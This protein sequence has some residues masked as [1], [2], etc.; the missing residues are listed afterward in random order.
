MNPSSE[1]H[2][3]ERLSLDQGPM[4]RLLLEAGGEIQVGSCLR[5]FMWSR[6]RVDEGFDGVEIVLEVRRN[7]LLRSLSVDP[8]T[9]RDTRLPLAHWLGGYRRNKYNSGYF[10]DGTL[11]VVLSPRRLVAGWLLAARRPFVAGSPGAGSVFLGELTERNI[12]EHQ[13]VAIADSLSAEMSGR[14]RGS[15]VVWIEILLVHPRLQRQGIGRTMLEHLIGELA[16]PDDVCILEVDPSEYYY[17]REP[18][19]PD[20]PSTEGLIRFYESVGF[21][22]VRMTS[23]EAT[24][25]PLMFKLPR[26]RHGVSTGAS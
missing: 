9:S 15:S 13:R 24:G 17:G 18:D 23:A 26:R 20:S 10:S 16:Q 19:D 12:P 7:A 4:I 8:I 2:Q 1:R 25:K 5:S 11:K 22:L 14:P 6:T 21:Q 3:H